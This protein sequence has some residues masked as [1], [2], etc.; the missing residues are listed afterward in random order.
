MALFGLTPQHEYTTARE[1]LED[2]RHRTTE[3]KSGKQK[4]S[5]DEFA[6][7]RKRAAELAKSW[8]DIDCFIQIPTRVCGPTPRL[9]NKCAKRFAPRFNSPY[10]TLVRAQTIES[11]C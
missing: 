5:P 11:G 8:C 10:F 7:K 6:I 2:A 9:C 3:S 1:R 4:P